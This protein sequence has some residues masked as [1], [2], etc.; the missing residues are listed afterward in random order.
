MGRC[1]PYEITQCYLP[2]DTS[3]R[4]PHNLSHAGWYSIYLPR[5]DGRLSWPSWLDSAG[6]GSQ[7]S[8]LLITS[9]TLNR[10][11]RDIGLGLPHNGFLLW[12][13]YYR[14][15]Q[16]WGAEARAP[17]TSNCLI[18]SGHFRAAQTLTLDCMGFHVKKEDTYSFVTAYCTNFTTFFFTP[19]QHAIARYMPSPVRPSVC[20]SVT[21]VNQSKTVE[22]RPTDHATFTTE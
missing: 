18:F 17:S 2:P 16:L 10:Y 3:E 1:L 5:R 14:R 4:A 9:P 8:D 21:R 22:G 6:A 20:L 15:R 7:T 19:P 13:W 12:Y 11:H